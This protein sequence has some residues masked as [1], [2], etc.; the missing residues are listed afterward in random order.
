MKRWLPILA[1]IGPA[2]LL[3]LTAGLASAC[4]GFSGGLNLSWNDCGAF[5]QQNRNFACNTNTTNLATRHV[6]VGSYVAP[7]GIDSANGNTI[8][9][10]LQTSG[11]TLSDWWKYVNAGACRETQLSENFNTSS[12]TLP[13]NCYDYW[14]AQTGG[15]ATGSKS[16]AF[17]GPDKANTALLRLACAIPDTAAG[18]I[19]ERTETYSFSVKISNGK[20][21]G[22]GSCAGCTDA[23]CITLKSIE[24]T[25]NPHSTGGNKFIGNPATRNWITWRGGLTRCGDVPVLNRTWGQVKGLYR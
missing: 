17:P 25:Q 13:G 12:P 1:V 24:I 20:T 14:G 4:G 7:A 10:D 18:P 9:I 8:V 21:V 15:A 11:A 2:A 6:F 23:A 5:G 3:A 19:P 16:Y 22:L